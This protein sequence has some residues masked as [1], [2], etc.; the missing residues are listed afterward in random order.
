M[1]FKKL[2]DKLQV[3]ENGMTVNVVYP[4]VRQFDSIRAEAAYPAP[5]RQAAPSSSRAPHRWSG[6]F[7]RQLHLQRHRAT[8]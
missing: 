3:K 5:R 8:V 6:W 1:L 2:D 4:P 7:T